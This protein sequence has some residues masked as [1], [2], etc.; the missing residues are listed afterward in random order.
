MQSIKDNY[1]R[2]TDTIVE[3]LGAGT[4]P[5]IRPWRGNARRSLTPRR[6]TGEAYRGINV[7][8]L[9]VAGQTFGYEENTWMTYRQA[10]DLGA[11]VRKGEKGTLVVKY[12]TFTPKDHEDDEDRAI[13]YLKGYTVFNVEQIDSL[14][15]QF[16]SP[17]EELPT[18][19]VPH[20]DTVE[21]FVGNTRAKVSYGGTKACYRPSIDDILMPDRER[22]D[23]EVHLY[24]TL[25]HELAHFSGAKHRLDRDLTG[26]FGNEAYAMEECIAECTAA[27]LCADLGVDHDPRDNT[28]AYLASWVA[29][30]K[31]DKRAIITA[32]AKA[33]VAADYLT[34]LQP[35]AGLTAA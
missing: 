33:Q 20:I 11:Q 26:R 28:A 10:Q 5:W 6:A 25:L 21:A 4:K 35:G 1:Q 18:S 2:I 8:M 9:W 14:P 34:A 31:N 7:L 13:P 12:G 19:P 30:L 27:F 23:S 17:A 32:A 3:Q 22:F 15:D 29:V 24:S 16:F